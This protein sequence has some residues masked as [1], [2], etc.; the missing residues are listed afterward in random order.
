MALDQLLKCR[1]FQWDAGNAEK[2][3]IKHRVSRSESEQ[4]FFNRPLAVADDESHSKLERR[5]YALGH[6]DA[7]RPLFIVFAIRGDLIRVISARHM[8]RRERRL[9][10]EKREEDSEVQE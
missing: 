9:Y 6:T 4:V 10:D 3:W 1:G 2:N 5:Y 7:G 8:H